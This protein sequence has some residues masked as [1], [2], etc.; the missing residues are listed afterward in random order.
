MTH[1]LAGYGWTDDREAAFAQHAAEGRRPGRVAR[2]DHGRCEIVVADG[3][4]G[5]RPVRAEPPWR[6]DPLE[7]ICTGDWVA[8]DGA[9]PPAVIDLLTRTSAIVRT[10]AGTRSEGQVL[11]ANMDAVLIAVPVIGDWK[12]ARLERFLALAWASGAVPVVVLTKIDLGL[13]PWLLREA[14]ALAT[15]AEVLPVSAVSGEGLDAL[16][17]ALPLTTALIGTSGAGKST[18]VNA[19]VGAETMAVRAI[20]DSDGKG[21]HTTTTRELIRYPGG[22]LI[23]TPGLRGV[24]LY[25]DDE[26]LHRA[27][28]D[29]EELAEMCRFADCAH[30]AEPGCAVIEA[31]EDGR[32][33]ARRLD[34]YRRLQRESEWMAAR[35][36]ARLAQERLRRWKSLTRQAGTP[37]P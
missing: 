21:R 1:A 6:A 34:S 33:E 4:D 25:G 31:I 16:R 13:Q 24:G 22:V 19:L 10:V 28:A 15:G 27:F 18:L 5:V 37:R 11:A 17:A 30:G 20:R 29:V 7:R 8:L 2:V 32:L 14:T 35:T 26:G 36:D 23:D 3:P 12:P 9:D